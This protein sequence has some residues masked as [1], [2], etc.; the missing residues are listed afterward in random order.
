MTLYSI[1]A[2]IAIGHRATSWVGRQ[3]AHFHLVQYFQYLRKLL[4]ERLP[5]AKAV[6]LKSGHFGAGFPR[7]GLS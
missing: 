1:L 2:R 6:E 7:Q 4:R 5:T 3:V